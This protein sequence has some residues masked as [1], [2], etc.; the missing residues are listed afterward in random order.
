MLWRGKGD[1]HEW[2]PLGA[3]WFPNEMHVGFSR[4]PVALTCVTRDAGTHDVFPHRCPSAVAR[5][6]MIKIEIAPIEDLST[7]LAGVLVALENIVARKL[8][9][10]LRESIEKEQHYHARHANL[11]RNGRDH[12]IFRRGRGKIAPALEVVR[13]EIVCLIRRNDLRVTRINQRECAPRRAD[14]NRL[15]EPVQ[16]QNLTVQ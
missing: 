16:H 1:V 3:F 9:L 13:H 7:I 15:P 14:V 6:D 11:P 12:F 10:L 5:H 2:A 4:E 8:H